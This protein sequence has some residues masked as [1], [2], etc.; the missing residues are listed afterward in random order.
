[1]YRPALEKRPFWNGRRFWSSS[2]PE[3][4]LSQACAMRMKKAAAGG[5]GTW[6]ALIQPFGWVT[7]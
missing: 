7:H 2:K 4:S 6:A 3:P 1:M 5:A